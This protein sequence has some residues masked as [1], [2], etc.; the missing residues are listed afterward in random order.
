MRCFVGHTFV[1]PNILRRTIVG[2]VMERNLF[3]HSLCFRVLCLASL[4]GLLALS[5]YSYAQFDDV[6]FDWETKSDKAGIK[7]QTSKIKGSMYRAVRG[8]MIVEGS[9]PELFA[10]LKDLS[11]CS[12]WAY[13]CKESRLVKKLSA[14]EEVLYVYN[15]T[16]FPIKDRDVIAKAVWSRDQSSGKVSM[17]SQAL[18]V[19]QGTNLV[20]VSRSALRVSSAVIEWHFTPTTEG[21]TL[22]QNF[23]HVEPGGP[24]PA[25]LINLMLTNSP[26]I[27]MRNM[28]STIESGRYSS[29][30]DLPF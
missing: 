16:P 12:E 3:T 24:A 11:Y 6:Q 27:T 1:K 10:L 8:E 22:V 29:A 18:D 17:R 25:W 4:Y 2:R 7:I 5:G 13:L 30:A 15:D 26:V 21:K 20:P 23:A 14:R 19:D 9:V 28:R